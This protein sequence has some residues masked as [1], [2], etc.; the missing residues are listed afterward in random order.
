MKETMTVH[1]ALSELKILSN[2][3]EN[4]INS[5]TFVVTNKHSNTKISGEPV[6]EYCRQMKEEYQSIRTLIARRNAIKRA[7][8]R[9]NAVTK[10]M[11]AGVEL[12]VAEAIDMKTAGMEFVDSL[13]NK[14]AYQLNLAKNRADMENEKLVDRT[15]NY[16]KTMYASTDLKNMSEEM[17]K[18]RD[19]FVT[20]Q[21]FEIVD[22]I[23]VAQEVN[24]LTEQIDAFMS[25]VDSALSVSNALTTVEVEYDTF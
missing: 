15:D 19:N 24:E 13:K 14:L 7:V 6:N 11:V 10:V 1:K 20:S 3:I 17:Q 8:I 25:E 5:T 9:S 22:P 2:R 21:T 23:G 16:M 4:K 18:V 12:T